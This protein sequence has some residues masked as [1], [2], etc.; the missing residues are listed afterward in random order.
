ML[1]P[2][3]IYYSIPDENTTGNWR[4][5]NCP[6]A[7]CRPLRKGQHLVLQLKRPQTGLGISFG[8]IKNND[9]G[10]RMNPSGIN[11]RDSAMMPVIK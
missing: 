7:G 10:I 2:P 4:P 9:I 1:L 5:N 11:W 6:I 8:K 3:K